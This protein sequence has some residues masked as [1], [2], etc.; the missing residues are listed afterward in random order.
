[1]EIK[2]INCNIL[3]FN[4]KIKTMEN[5]ET[6]S[7]SDSEVENILEH[8]SDDKLVKVV[9]NNSRLFP[10]AQI[11]IKRR[12]DR[13]FL[14]LTNEIEPC[15]GIPWTIELL[16]LFGKEI[17][18]IKL[19]YQDEHRRMDQTIEKAINKNCAESIER[20]HLVNVSRFSMSEIE[21]PFKK[22]REAILETGTV[23]SPFSNIPKWFPIINKLQLKNLVLHSTHDSNCLIFIKPCST[24]ESIRIDNLKS[25]NGD[26]GYLEEISLLVENKINLKKLTICNQENID[27]LL[28]IC[29]VVRPDQPSLCLD[30]YSDKLT[31]NRFIQFKSL[32]RLR[33]IGM[34]QPL[35]I[36]T[37]HIAHLDLQYPVFDEEWLVLLKNNKKVT[38][39]TTYG[40]WI[41]GDESCFIDIVKSMP[42][43]QMLGIDTQFSTDHIRDVVSSCST[44]ETIHFHR[45]EYSS[46]MKD[47]FESLFKSFENWSWSD[48][49][50][51]FYKNGVPNVC[52]YFRSVKS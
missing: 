32:Q 28:A 34:R 31:G 43:L 52:R 40:K 18:C 24:L 14:C 15:D 20:I 17:K 50:I 25:S 9:R 19:V 26:N 45:D 4:F 51:I 10:I 1:M 6:G 2:L 47:D 5:L 37:D 49:E 30:I 21:K 48:T 46:F 3:S 8:L 7:Y 36:S 12:Y 16:E 39:L 41:C 22:L 35:N 33:I 29:A 23:C 11:I 27:E 13:E 42:K 38:K 44:L